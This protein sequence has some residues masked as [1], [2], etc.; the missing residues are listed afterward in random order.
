[1]TIR[2]RTCLNSFSLCFLVPKSIHSIHV[3]PETKNTK[4]RYDFGRKV[5]VTSFKFVKLYGKFGDQ[6][7]KISPTFPDSLISQ[8]NCDVLLDSFNWQVSGADRFISLF[9]KFCG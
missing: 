3:S 4:E 9:E 6:S 5:V 7:F 1:M 8:R 2:C